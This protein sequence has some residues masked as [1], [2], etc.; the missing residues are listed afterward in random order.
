MTGQD[1]EAAAADI[2]S[3]RSAAPPERSLL[4]ALDVVLLEGIFLLKRE[5]TTL[6]DR[7]L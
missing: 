3:A 2:G 1:I 4:V 6:Y 7:T 5:L